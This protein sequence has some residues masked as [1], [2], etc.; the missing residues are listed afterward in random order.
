MGILAY[1]R[2][3]TRHSK[4]LVP[5]LNTVTDLVIFLQP[6]GSQVDRPHPDRHQRHP[7][8]P[9]ASL[10]QEQEVHPAGPATQ[11]DTCHAPTTHPVRGLADY[12]AAAQEADPLPAAQVCRQGG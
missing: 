10:L 1:N 8:R 7:A 2:K 4:N 12:R 3:P 6:R 9:A 11:E 5:T